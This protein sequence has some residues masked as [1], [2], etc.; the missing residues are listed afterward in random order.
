[1]KNKGQLMIFTIILILLC[2]ITL[3]GCQLAIPATNTIAT[4]D[5]LCG[6]FVTIGYNNLPMNE[7]ALTDAKITIGNDGKISLD[8]SINSSLF[9]NRI[10]GKLNKEKNTVVFDGISGYYMGNLR[11][12]DE[13]GESYNSLMSDPA[14]TD[15][16]YAI[17]VTDNSEE[18]KGEA[19]LYVSKQFREAFYLNPVY[20]T[21]DGSYY[22]ILGNSQGTSFSGEIST[23]CS[24]TIDS[25]I[26]TKN[27]DSS[28]TEK[29][30]YKINV[31]VVE[32][33]KKTMIKE[34]NQ[35]DELIKVTEHLPNSQ[36]E[37]IVDSETSYI[38]VEE[39][40]DSSGKVNNVKRSVYVPLSR[41]SMETTNQ[42]RCNYP[43]ENNI[44]AQKYVK[45][46]YE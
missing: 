10:E 9:E 15:V 32:T 1:M 20:L 21:G 2:T 5:K 46:I 18:Q 13:N 41:D 14:L 11:S 33:V 38:I 35:K 43:G 34:M 16:K 39:V 25:A 36:D 27:D 4:T 26:T 45:F 23:V 28:K 17:N 44:I 42:H 37:F 24:Q 40:L 7:K 19:T 8:E 12:Q 6:V 31:A 3:T 30:S 22:T 29:C